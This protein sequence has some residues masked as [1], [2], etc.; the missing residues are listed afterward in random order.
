MTHGHLQA[1]FEIED[2]CWLNACFTKFGAGGL[3][4]DV[5]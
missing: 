2:A 5:M 3:R 4:G 1:F